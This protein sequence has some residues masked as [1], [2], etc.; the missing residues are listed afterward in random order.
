MRVLTDGGVVAV[1]T[2]TV[3]GLAARADL[4]SAVERLRGIKDRSPGQALTWH[5][6]SLRPLEQDELRWRLSPMARRLAQRYWP[7]PLTLVLPGVPRGLEAAAQDGWIG[8]RL[9]A[10]AAT[11]ELL[12][13]LPFPVVATSANRRG[14][15]ALADPQAIAREFAGEVELVL[16]SGPPRLGESSAVLRLGPGHF[17]L[18]RPG[19]VDLEHL[20]RTAGLRIV[21]VCTGNTCRSPMACVQATQALARRLEVP[22]TRIGEFGFEISSSGVAASGG[23]RI[24]RHALEVLGELGPEYERLAR[25]HRT[26]PAIPEDLLEADRIYAL[27][28][29]HLEILRAML[30]PARAKHL[31]LLDPSGRDVPDPIGSDLS[32]Y[33]QCRG[34]LGGADRAPPR[35]VGLRR[36]SANGGEGVPGSGTTTCADQASDER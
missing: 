24:A 22:R 21:F 33:R 27:T 16:D 17:E 11:A 12:D 32:E 23:G 29:S 13:S 14:R 31:A 35:G 19:L 10:H 25:E 15:P 30:P 5:V 1:P 26:E 34:P 3:Y 2:E 36:G 28:N 18:L 7:G 9:P 4:P 20:R 6:G 8:V